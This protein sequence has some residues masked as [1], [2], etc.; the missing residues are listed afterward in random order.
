MR[1]RKLLVG[2]VGIE[3]NDGMDFKD[4]RGMQRS[5]KSLKRNDEGGEGILHSPLKLPRFPHI[6]NSLRREFVRSPDSEI[7]FWPNSRGTDG[8]PTPNFDET[9]GGS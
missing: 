4:L 6:F 1:E 9:I 2:A 7:G 3:N 8:K 5:A